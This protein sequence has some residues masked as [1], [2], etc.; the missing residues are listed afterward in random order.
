MERQESK[1]KGIEAFKNAMTPQMKNL[2]KEV[3]EHQAKPFYYQPSILANMVNT[4]Y[5]DSY[6]APEVQNYCKKYEV[7]LS[8]EYQKKYNLTLV[9]YLRNPQFHLGGHAPRSN[10]MKKKGM[11][12]GGLGLDADGDAKM[13]G[14]GAG[15]KEAGN[16]DVAMGD[17]DNPYENDF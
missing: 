3:K 13:G 8:S 15:S 1:A 14:T 16:G 2:Y 11:G 4:G 9:A 12:A 10:G 6:I 17:S 5:G 7:N